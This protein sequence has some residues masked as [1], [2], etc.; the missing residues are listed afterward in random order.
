MVTSVHYLRLTLLL[1]VLGHYDIM[2][3]STLSHSLF[4][5]NTIRSTSVSRCEMMFVVTILTLIL[6]LILTSILLIIF[7]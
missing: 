4:M 3:F 2:N 7:L 6:L 5:V 1:T